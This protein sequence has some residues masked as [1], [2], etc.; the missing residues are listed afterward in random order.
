M[1]FNQRSKFVAFSSVLLCAC[2]TPTVVQSVKPGDNG[3]SCAQLQNEYVDAERFRSEAD[4]EKSVTGGNVVR[5]LL[6]WPAILGTASNAN[7]AI[8]A[9]DSRKVHLA[10]QMNQKNC[11]IPGVSQVVDIK[12]SDPTQAN[13][14]S[15]T[16]TNENNSQ[17]LRDL[18]TLRKDGVITEEE[19][20]K[21]KQQ[22]LEKL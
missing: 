6:F 8:A 1:I 14:V 11:S 13:T 9:A 21:K 22:I 16:P 5:A 19:F 3:L 4:K 10:N 17:K 20:L 18:Q 7:E 2:A 15:G 12:V